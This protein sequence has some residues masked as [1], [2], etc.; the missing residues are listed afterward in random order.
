MNIL[1]IGNSFSQDAQR[2]L[3]RLAGP[4]A[5]ITAVNL[6]IGGCSLERHFRNMMGDSRDYDME[7]NG[8][9]TGFKTSIK[10]ALLTRAWDVV[11]LQ[12]CSPRSPYFDSYE[13]YLQLLA[14]EVR[15]LCPGAKLWIHETWGYEDGSTRLQDMGRYA[16]MKEMY[17]DVHLA[18]QKAAE[19]IHADGIIPAGRG[20]QA[21]ADM[22][23]RAHRDGFHAN[24]DY[25][26]YMLG[27]VWYH[28]LLGGD[29]AAN[30]FDQLDHPVTAEEL[31]AAKAAA[32]AAFAD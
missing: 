21:L 2:Y 7:F 32:A 10:E 9:H 14:A 17:A 26:R 30:T 8:M 22:G 23:F 20:M 31:A 6:Y 27:L 1:S 4:E 16:S 19:A 12:Q 28:A 3:V 18:Y 11:T 15:R 24:Y 13:P 29:I 25:G 5:K